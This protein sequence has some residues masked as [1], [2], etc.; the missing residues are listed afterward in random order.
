MIADR[1][2][3]NNRIKFVAKSGVKVKHI[4]QRK[5][6]FRKACNE[7]DGLPCVSSKDNNSKPLELLML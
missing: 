2:S 6:P 4:V 3:D 5:N 7:N 1:I